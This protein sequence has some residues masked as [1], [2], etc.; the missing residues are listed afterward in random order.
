[1]GEPTPPGNNIPETD[2]IAQHTLLED[3]TGRPLPC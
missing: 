1:M 2:P 3:A